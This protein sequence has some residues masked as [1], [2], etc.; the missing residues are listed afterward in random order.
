M[1]ST[2]DLGLADVLHPVQGAFDLSG[3]YVFTA[4]DDDILD[5]ARQVQIPFLVEGAQIA[6]VQPSVLV[7]GLLLP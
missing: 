2:H 6:G 7:N 3:R 5:A 4:P 1:R